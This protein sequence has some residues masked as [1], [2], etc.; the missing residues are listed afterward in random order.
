[1]PRFFS[2]ILYSIGIR[3]TRFLTNPYWQVRIFLVLFWLTV[4]AIITGIAAWVW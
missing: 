3:T 1:M 2:R 4:M